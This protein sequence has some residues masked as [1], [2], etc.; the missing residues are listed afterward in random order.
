MSAL[1]YQ[2]AGLHTLSYAWTQHDA[3]EWLVS[4]LRQIAKGVDEQRRLRYDDLFQGGVGA[5]GGEGG[6]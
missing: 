4:T 2:H 3:L 1:H 5:G 6:G